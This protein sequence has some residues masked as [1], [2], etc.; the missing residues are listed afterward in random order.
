MRGDDGETAANK[1]NRCQ[2]ISGKHRDHTAKSR[3]LLFSQSNKTMALHRLIKWVIEGVR[4]LP[5]ALNISL[6][7][8]VSLSNPPMLS[9]CLSSLL[10]LTMFP[11]WF[12]AE[13][14]A[15]WTNAYLGS[16]SETQPRPTPVRGYGNSNY[17]L[18]NHP[19]AIISPSAYQCRQVQRDSPAHTLSFLWQREV[20]EVEMWSKKRLLYILHTNSLGTVV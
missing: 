15:C 2:P 19:F 7:S 8:C 17:L 4:A 13:L 18:N 11:I 3:F 1:E 12:A 14:D 20:M 16:G 9:L 10:F 6:P 5:S